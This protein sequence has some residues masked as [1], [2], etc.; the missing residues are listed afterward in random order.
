MYKHLFKILLSIHLGID[1]EMELLEHVVILSLIFKK[2]PCYFFIGAVHPHKQLL[3]LFF[4]FFFFIVTILM[5]V[6]LNSLTLDVQEK[7][8]SSLL[9]IVLGNRWEN[10]S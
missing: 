4:S 10:W 1:P 9:R 3:L 8:M 5:C 2:P 7:L 6:K